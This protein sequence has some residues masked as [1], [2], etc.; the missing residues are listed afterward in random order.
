MEAV[1]H[2]AK[3]LTEKETRRVRTE[4]VVRTMRRAFVD[5]DGQLRTMTIRRKRSDP[6][7]PAYRKVTVTLFRTEVQEALMAVAHRETQQT[8]N[9]GF[10]AQAWMDWY[11]R[12]VVRPKRV[13]PAAPAGGP[14]PVPPAGNPDPANP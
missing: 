7:H 11:R 9:Y 6:F 2:L 10:D 12:N 4:T 13:A 5:A 14:P 1:P 3:A 8:V